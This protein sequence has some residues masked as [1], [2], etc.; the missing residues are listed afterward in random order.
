MLELTQMKNAQKI[1]KIVC[2]RFMIVDCFLVLKFFDFDMYSEI[3]EFL[4]WDC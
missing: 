2:L 1:M 4:E 3:A